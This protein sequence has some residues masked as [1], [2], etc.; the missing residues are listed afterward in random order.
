MGDTAAALGLDHL[1]TLEATRTI[2]VDP[3]LDFVLWPENTIDI[4]DLRATAE[5]ETFAMPRVVDPM[6]S[7]RIWKIRCLMTKKPMPER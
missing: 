5:L 1:L 3:E 4:D 7:C 2:A 6:R